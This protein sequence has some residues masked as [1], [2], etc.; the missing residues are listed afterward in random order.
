MIARTPDGTTGH[1]RQD[2]IYA[3]MVVD[4]AAERFRIAVSGD[5]NLYAPIMRLEQIATLRWLEPR[6]Q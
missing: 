5:F 4:L 2:D 3:G 1:S 6:L